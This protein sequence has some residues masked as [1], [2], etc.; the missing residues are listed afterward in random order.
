MTTV[1]TIYNQIAQNIVNSI[2]E[3]WDE[4]FINFSYFGDSAK[5][6][7]KYATLLNKEL[8]DFK[9]GYNSYVLFKELHNI[10]TEDS[11]NKWNKAK[12]TLKRNGEFN[13]DFEWDQDLADEIK[14]LS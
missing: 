9:V 6:Q 11:E 8:K 12:F 13:I 2:Q 7:G 14:R 5:Y 1:N 10:T 3:P 4:A